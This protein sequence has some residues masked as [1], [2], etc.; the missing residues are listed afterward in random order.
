MTKRVGRE[1][2]ACEAR[3]GSPAHH[4]LE[5][6]RLGHVLACANATGGRKERVVGLELPSLLEELVNRTLGIRRDRHRACL[7]SF[8]TADQKLTIGEIGI[9]D[10][11]SAELGGPDAGIEQH[12]ED[13]RLAPTGFLGGGLHGAQLGLGKGLHLIG[14]VYRWIDALHGRD[15]EISLGHQPVEERANGAV[16][17]LDGSRRERPLVVR[18]SPDALRALVRVAQVL[19]ESTKLVNPKLVELALLNKPNEPTKA[20]SAVSQRSKRVPRNIAME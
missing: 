7:A 5:R 9:G 17:A 11:E 15:I 18:D 1:A 3:N 16:V 20:L 6:A 12:A 14:P 2:S 13:G 19:E 10:S 8:A 4:H